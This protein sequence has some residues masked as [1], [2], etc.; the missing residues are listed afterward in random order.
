VSLS[1][2]AG[3]KFDKATAMNVLLRVVE[4]V[5]AEAGVDCVITS[6]KDG[7]HMPSSKH[8]KDEALDFR[9]SVF[10]QKISPYDALKVRKLKEGVVGT[11]KQRLGAQYDVVLESDHIHVEWD[12]KEV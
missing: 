1:V 2:K 7:E 12:P 3:V 11:I 8:Y 4:Q 10:A 6:G 9:T 5:Y